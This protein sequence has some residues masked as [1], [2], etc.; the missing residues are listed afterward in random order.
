VQHWADG[1]KAVVEVKD[2][3]VGIQPE[4]LGHIF[5]GFYRGARAR[6]LETEGLGLGLTLAQRFAAAQGGHI[7]VASVV[8]QGSTFRVVLP[9]MAEVEEQS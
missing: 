4:D 2:T 3:G 1:D 7:E 8:G 9:L 5:D 6:D